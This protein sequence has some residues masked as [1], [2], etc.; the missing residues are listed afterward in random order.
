MPAVP[1]NRD[2]LDA[3]M[4][5][6]HKQLRLG[7]KDVAR[8]AG[9]GERTVWSV[10]KE[11]HEIEDQTM[12]GIET[13]LRWE[14]GSVQKI[15]DGHDPV[16]LPVTEP[17]RPLPPVA[18]LP[19]QGARWPSG[20]PADDCEREHDD[21]MARY[22]GARRG[23]SEPSGAQIFAGMPDADRDAGIWDANRPDFEP[24]QVAEQ[25]AVARVQRAKRRAAAGLTA[26]TS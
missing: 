11:R 17:P 9:I 24:E 22:Y 12:E 20:L 8:L 6:R 4:D 1:A 16:P 15:L 26:S 13:A 5:E 21:V 2:R 10:R 25:I 7:W 23:G 3:L 14:P 18:Q 19:R